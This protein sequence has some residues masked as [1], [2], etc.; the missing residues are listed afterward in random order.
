MVVQEEEERKMD[1][2]MNGWNV[3]VLD[4]DGRAKK[5]IMYV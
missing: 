1:G 4:A 3:G 2:C 5:D